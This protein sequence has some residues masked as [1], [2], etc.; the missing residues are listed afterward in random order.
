MG[1]G[2]NEKVSQFSDPGVPRFFSYICSQI[3]CPNFITLTANQ[4]Q[5]KLDGKITYKPTMLNE[6]KINKEDKLTINF[7]KFSMTIIASL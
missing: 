5:R 2:L 6:Q 4:E 7:S 1:G 3:T